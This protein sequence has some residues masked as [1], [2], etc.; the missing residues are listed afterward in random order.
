MRRT[1]DRQKELVFTTHGG[2]R[3]GAGRKPTGERPGVAHGSRSGLSGR[4]PVLVTLKVGKHVGNL[5]TRRAFE[6]IVPAFFAARGRGI[7]LAQFSVQHDHLHLIVEA[8]DRSS[9]SRGVQG[10]S[11]RIARALNR[12]T[13]RTG[14]VFADRFHDRVLS[15][16]R[17]I[18]TALAYVLCNARK[19]GKA[20]A[21]RGWL[22][23]Y[24]SGAAFDGWR[25]ASPD[26]LGAMPAIVPPRTWLL[27]L[28]WR[29]GGLIDPDHCPGAMPSSS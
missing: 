26:A 6:Q 17:Q 29:R 22:D 18:R 1:R 21:G 28:G 24:S 3:R 19:H 15:T 25:G 12:M 7:R 27:A 20:P 11:V 4:E 10:L 2:K 9:L 8:D 14:K 13:Q 16:P 23:P 5:R